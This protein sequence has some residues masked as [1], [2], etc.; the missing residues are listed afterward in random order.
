MN[1][2]IGNPNTAKKPTRITEAVRKTLG[3]ESISFNDNDIPRCKRRVTGDAATLFQSPSESA[4]ESAQSVRLADFV[5]R[6]NA[7]LIT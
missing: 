5:A 6:A 2:H 1:H 7:T 3:R 4:V